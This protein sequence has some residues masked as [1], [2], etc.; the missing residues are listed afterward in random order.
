MCM[1]MGMC[2]L[3]GMQHRALSILGKHCTTELQPHFLT[4]KTAFLML[5]GMC[6]LFML[7][8]ALSSYNWFENV[9][10]FFF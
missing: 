1:C 9:F 3:L 4:V 2:L 7:D 10:L 6:S 8:I 5:N